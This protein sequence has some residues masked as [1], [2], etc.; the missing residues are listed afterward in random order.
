MLAV[1]HP[2][3]G[4][5]E[6]DRFLGPCHGDIE[7]AA[8]LLDVGGRSQHPSGREQILLQ[9]GDIDVRKFQTFGRMYG[10]QGDLVVSVFLVLHINVGQ[11]GDVLKKCSEGEDRIFNFGII[12]C[13]PFRHQ[14]AAIAFPLFFNEV[15]DTVDKLLDIGCPRLRLN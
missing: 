4:E 9:T 13:L 5:R 6:A 7:Q 14:V 10:H 8:L 1:A 3:V 2:C 15:G 12:L 11:Q